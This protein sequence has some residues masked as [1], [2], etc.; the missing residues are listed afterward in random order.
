MSRRLFLAGIAA[1]LLCACHPELTEPSISVETKYCEFITQME[2]LDAPTKTSMDLNRNIIWSAGDQ[3]AVFQGSS[4]ADRYQVQDSDACSPNATF[5][6]IKET[7]SADSDFVGGT[8]ISFDTNIAFYPYESDLACTPRRNE[9]DVITSY[10][11]Q[12][13]TIPTIQKY[14]AGSF[15]EETFLMAAVTSDLSDHL[16]KFKNVCGAIRLQLKG[17]AQVSK[18]ELQGN[19]KEALTG[20][21][22]DSRHQ[23]Y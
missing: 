8:E 15:Q 20:F 17:T 5:S 6:I 16:L 7:G 10:E 11:I 19:C 3:V 13:V 23:L 18:T 2:G 1:L 9:D 21:F 22:S 12:N 14:K 4:I